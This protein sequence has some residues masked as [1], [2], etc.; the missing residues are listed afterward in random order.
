MATLTKAILVA[1]LIEQLDLTTRE[2][3][4][5]VELF[6]YTISQSL[7]T[8]KAVHISGFGNFIL[9]DKGPRPGRNPKTKQAFAI[10]AR[11][12]VVFR[13][14]KKLRRL[15]PKSVNDV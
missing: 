13:P 10:E 1:Q 15:I 6:F 8:G 11:R 7:E 4:Q 3:K 5:L 2:A 9:R 12:V 14:G